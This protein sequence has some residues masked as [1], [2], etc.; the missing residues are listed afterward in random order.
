MLCPFCLNEVASFVAEEDASGRPLLVCP[1]KA[2]R[3][4]GVP[5]LYA[6]DYADYPPLPFS[7]V[8]LPGH[9]KTVFLTSLFHEFDE[10]GR[11][12]PAF[13]WAPLD[14]EGMPEV[15]QKL[16][17]PPAGPPPETTNTVFPPPH[18]LPL[19]TA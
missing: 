16:P 17:P 5:L 7:I 3:E 2:C 6:Q 18:I 12:W 4:P 13:Y 1:E 8:G 15:R 19:T 10:L 9:G 11:R 14:E